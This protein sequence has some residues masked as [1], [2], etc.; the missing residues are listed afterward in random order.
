[1]KDKNMI[2]FKQGEFSIDCGPKF[3]G[4]TDGS[5]WNG[6]ACPWFTMETM[7]SIQEWVEDG[8]NV[9][10]IAIEGDKIFDVY[11]S[12]RIEMASTVIDGVTYYSIDGWCWDQEDQ[13]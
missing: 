1:M 12:E 13:S 3:Q 10:P 2:T 7:K 4:I 8:I 6:W 5:L 9:N 11:E